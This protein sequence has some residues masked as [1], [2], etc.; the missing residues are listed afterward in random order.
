MM[1]SGLD[2]RYRFVQRLP[3]LLM[4][5]N[6]YYETKWQIALHLSTS[7]SVRPNRSTI[8]YRSL[9]GLG[10]DGPI[11]FASFRFNHLRQLRFSMERNDRSQQING[12]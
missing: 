10:T 1:T 8:N 11:W 6:V 12:S 3:M 2:R 9:V 7:L 5:L 4:L